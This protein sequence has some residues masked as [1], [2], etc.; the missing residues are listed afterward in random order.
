MDSNE[1]IQD[2]CI[3]GRKV[4][5]ALSI[6]YAELMGMADKYTMEI[7]YCETCGNI[8][9][10]NPFN[11]EKLNNRYTNFSKFE[12]DDESY[13]FDEDQD[14]RNR[15]NR[16]R[17]F[18]SRSIDYSD[19]DSMLEVGAASGYNLSLYKDKLQVLGVEPSSNNCKNAM[20]KYGV[21]E[22]CGVFKQFYAEMKGKK[23]WDI[24]F[25][26]HT[27]EHIVNPRKF[28]G[29]CSELNSKYIFIEV[30]TFDYKFSNE[31]YGMFCE[32]HVNLFTLKSLQ[33]LMN[34]SGYSLVNAEI[35]MC[36]GQRMPAAFPSM[37]SLWKKGEVITQKVVNDPKGVMELYVKDS[38]K[39]LESVRKIIREIPDNERLALWGTGHHFSFLL[40][41]TDLLTKNI[42][43]VYDSDKRKEGVPACGCKIK[44]FDPEEIDSVIDSVVILS[45]VALEPIKKALEKYSGKLKIYTLY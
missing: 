40:A 44:P 45:Y 39:N 37:V 1:D 17:D 33:S 13:I 8:F 7:G 28:I 6:K 19:V 9:V 22:Y 30:P 10:K 23:K 41:N 35:C 5:T 12:F 26:S 18:I 11:E 4:P 32:E 3:C 20:K 24:I 42:V 36:I 27:L 43:R 21:E 14:Y 29:E 2:C 25:L 34:S 16:Q 15:S 31:P 38:E